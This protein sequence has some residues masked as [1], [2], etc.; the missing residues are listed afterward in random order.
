LALFRVNN[1]EVDLGRFTPR[2]IVCLFV[3]VIVVFFQLF[4]LLE[5]VTFAT[6]IACVAS[7][8]LL[9]PKLFF[10]IVAEVLDC[11]K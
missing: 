3:F 11:D 2:S 6:K 1:T 9:V 7:E 5:H 10:G 8:V 4:M